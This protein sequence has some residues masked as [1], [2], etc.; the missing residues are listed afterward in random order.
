MTQN[1]TR[2]LLFFFS[3]AI[4]AGSIGFLRWRPLSATESFGK[5]KGMTGSPPEVHRFVSDATISVGTSFYRAL[6]GDLR[7]DRVN[8]IVAGTDSSH[9]AYV[10]RK[11]GATYIE[12]WNNLYAAGDVVHAAAVGDVDNDG[13]NEFLISVRSSGMIYMYRWNGAT[14]QKVHE[15]YFGGNYMPAAIFDIDRDGQNELIVD[16]SGAGAMI[17]V[18][19]Y[20][21]GSGTFLLA[22]SAPKGNVLQIAVGDPDNDGQ[23]E[24]V[25]AL[26]WD[27]PPGKLMI[28]GYD[29][30]AYS[31]ENTLTSFASGLGG[32]A[33]ADF[34]GDGKQEI[35]TGMYN[36]ASAT[37][38]VYLVKHDGAQYNVTTLC[39][40]GNG[41]FH[42]HA[43]DIDRDGL[44]EALVMRNGEAM[45]VEFRNSAYSAILM[46]SYGGRAGDLADMDGDNRAEM[47]TTPTS[48]QIISDT[49]GRSYLGADLDGNGS[50]EIVGDLA[51][52]GLWYWIST[53]ANWAQL[54]PVEPEGMSAVEID[55]DGADEIAADF[56]S[57]GLWIWNGGAWAQIAGIHLQGLTAGDLDASGRDAVIADFGPTGLWWYKDGAWFQLT[58]GNA[59]EM[60]SA[61]FDSD[62]ADEIAV[63]FGSLGLWLWN[64]GTWTQ[65]SV[66]DANLLARVDIDGLGGQELIASFGTAG[67]WLWD[68][69]TWSQ[70]ST[71]S[72]EGVV[73]ING[74]AVAGEEIFA[75]FGTLGLWMLTGGTWTQLSGQNADWLVA[76]DLNN[77]GSG[78]IAG[79][80]AGSGLWIFLSNS[81]WQQYSALNADDLAVADTDGDGFGELIADFGPSGVWLNNNG[82]WSQIK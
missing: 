53:S 46:P 27:Y 44:P 33:V 11:E 18:F 7:N 79:D 61:N 48:I 25:V 47:I 10:F 70:L 26:P 31:V 8:R 21:S 82:T 37:Y 20:D 9:Y 76:S 63:D 40:A 49:A 6:A 77:D 5:G 60:I 67:L 55:G 41:T 54:T 34:D 39:D 64:G 24:A 28:I 59:Q 66:L 3:F 12:E 81:S 68:E 62:G 56:G 65:L 75:D 80:F 58:G 73:A 19:N 2:R 78:D 57:L 4:V 71:F 22:W 13:Q 38:P 51:T 23:L 74:N 17:S 69:G 43:G 14:Y 50:E 52:Q 30:A 42:I 35:I 16:G 29:G 32:A 15:Q 36:V 45:V 72:A 1:S